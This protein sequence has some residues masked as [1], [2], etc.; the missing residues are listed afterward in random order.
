MVTLPATVYSQQIVKKKLNVY[1]PAV[2]LTNPAV[3]HSIN[4]KILQRTNEL[5]RQQ[6]Y[7]ENPDTEETGYYELKTNERNVLSLTLVNFAYSGGAHGLTVVVPLTFNVLTGKTYQ[8]KDLFKK[9][10][11]YVSVLSKIVGAQIKERDIMVLGEYK[12][13]KPDQDFYIA[14]KSLVL[15]YQL[16]DLAPYAYGIPY[17]PISIYAIQD[18]I[19]DES[20]LGQMFG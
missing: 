15:F 2:H 14:D 20:P 8:L 4:S 6:G 12:G 3:Q 5:I 17:F 1:Y 18:I 7:E 9:D 16:Y 10:S 19:A 11:N 13:I